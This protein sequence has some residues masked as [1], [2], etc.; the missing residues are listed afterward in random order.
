MPKRISKQALQDMQQLLDQGRLSDFYDTMGDAGYHYADWANGV[1]KVDSLAGISAVD[2]LSGSAIIG[3][4]TQACR[5]ITNDQFL[6]IK[7]DMAQ[8]YLDQLLKDAQGSGYV[9]RDLS[10]KEVYD[11][12]KQVFEDN[13]LG[14]ENWTL[15]APFKVMK[16]LFGQDGVD[17]IWERLRDTGGGSLSASVYNSAIWALMESMRLSPDAAMRELAE[18]WT[19]N[20]SIPDALMK[21][22]EQL[23]K[24]LFPGDLLDRFR[25]IFSGPLVTGL[26]P[27]IS[28][29]VRDKFRGSQGSSSPLLFD[30]DGDG[31]E[32]TQLSAR[33]TALFDLNADGIRTQM[34][35][36]GPDD[37]FLAL[38]RNGNGQIDSGRELFG[39]QT[40]LS[41]GKRATD[42][43][44]ALADLDSNHDGLINAQ[45]TRFGELRLWRD[46]NQDGV[47]G[48][49]EWQS[50]AQAGVTEIK[51][52][53]TA[54]T[55]TLADG[56]RLDGSASFTLHGLARTYTDAWL[57]ENPFT[58]RFSDAPTLDAAARNLP[59]MQGSGAVRDLREAAGQSPELSR[60]LTAFSQASTR[61]A[62]QAL[63][64]PI[65]NAWRDTS[66][67]VTVARWEATGHTVSY[68]FYGQDAAGNALWKQRLSTL[69]AFNGENYRTLARTGT[70]AISTA[71]ARQALLAQSYQALSES[72][73]SALV[74]QTRLKPYLDGISLFSPQAN[75]QADTSGLSALLATRRA[76]NPQAALTDLV[77]LNRYAARLLAAADFDGTGQ[78]R[79][80][81]EAL[82]AGSPLWGTLAELS[83][84]TGDAT[85][86]TGSADIYLGNARANRYSGGDGNDLID[87][88]QGNDRLYG[89]DGDDTLIGG[90][91][92]DVL[93]GGTGK[94]TLID[95][96]SSNEVYVW[97]R[98]AGADTLRDAGGVDR[99][100]VAAGVTAEQIWLQRDGSDL[101]LSVVGTQDSLNIRGWFDAPEAAI[102]AIRLADGKTLTANHVQALVDAMATLAPPPAG[103][104]TLS[105]DKL[106]ALQGVLAANW[107]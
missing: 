3:V 26:L 60:L 18:Q 14:I 6:N 88:G 56:T 32:V 12:H 67:L 66:A 55:Q 23:L 70:T 40:V 15:D 104:S 30:L 22:A 1:V 96:S 25:D 82:P 80:W 62:Q 101:K 50:L 5:N 64:E 33:S 53:K 106:A 105:A 4:G 45:D 51:L 59:Q 61:P 52:A 21:R 75:G 20:V 73:Y 74:V 35:W 34:A 95:L 72:V 57:A 87:G 63:L 13:R 79:A 78:L 86:G 9:E 43:Y 85:V 17:M 27:Q 36:A 98:D 7:Q 54:G 49:D 107:Q 41:N 92:N 93:E 100:D 103:P 44:A 94:D 68:N 47:G 28:D 102:E 81:V 31:I 11:I 10:S 69:E 90:A 77:E 99:L 29:L 24:D 65:L 19:S 8:A 89:R 39:D 84:Q 48:S 42:G 91:G 83:V 46:A 37:A 38:D 2:Y 76:S 58:R 71:S 97:G 16:K